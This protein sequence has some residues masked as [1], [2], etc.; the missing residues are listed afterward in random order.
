MYVGIGTQIGGAGCLG[1]II[2]WGIIILVAV[3]I[4]PLLLQAVITGVVLGLV[5]GVVWWLLSR[6]APKK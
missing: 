4:L 1:F 6:W 5:A 2:V 3:N